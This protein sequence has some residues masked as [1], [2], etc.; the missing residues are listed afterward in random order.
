MVPLSR[1]PMI[2]PCR[3]R[4]HIFVLAFVARVAKFDATDEIT[5]SQFHDFLIFHILIQELI[6][7]QL[8]R[9]GHSV[10]NHL[11]E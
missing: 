10:R 11:Q 9:F 8:Y 6:K 5:A 1:L 3:F 2:R 7:V 4:I